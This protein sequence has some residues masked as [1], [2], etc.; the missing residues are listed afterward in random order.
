MLYKF[1]VLNETTMFA[2]Y[3]MTLL[4]TIFQC[5]AFEMYKPNFEK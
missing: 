3:N 1:R 5:D 2:Q 4:F